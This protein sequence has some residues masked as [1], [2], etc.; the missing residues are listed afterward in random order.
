MKGIAW[1]G[2][3]I[4][5]NTALCD[6]VL[7]ALALAGAVTLLKALELAQEQVLAVA[8]ARSDARLGDGADAMAGAGAVRALLEI[9]KMRIL[10]T[11]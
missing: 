1:Q 2:T 7:S 4:K 5:C 10:A 6:A 3:V 9:G 8:V 11:S